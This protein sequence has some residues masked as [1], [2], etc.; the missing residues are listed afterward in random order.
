MKTY[1][2][3][4]QKKFNFTIRRIE[5][6][7]A[8]EK[9]VE[10]TD[11][12]CRGLLFRIEKTG[13]KTWRWRGTDRVS[14]KRV[15]L[16]L[17]TYPEMSLEDARNA[18]EENNLNL[19]EGVKPKT[20]LQK[21]QE[22]ETL[23]QLFER[24]LEEYAKPRK[25]S[26][27][28]DERQ[29]NRY[30]RAD[31]GDVPAEDITTRDLELW[32]G[33]LLK[34]K[35]ERGNG[36]L[37]TSTINRVHIVLSAVFSKSAKHIPNPA[38]GLEKYPTKHRNTF[39]KREMIP[40][41]LKALESEETPL[42]L[43]DLV[44]L[45]LATGARR[46]NLQTMTWREISLVDKTWT[47]P[48]DKMKNKEELVIPLSS[49]ALE[50]LERRDEKKTGLYVFPSRPGSKTPYLTEPKRAWKNLTERANLSG[51]RFHDLRRTAGSIM[52]AAGVP[53]LT[54]VRT[55]GQKSPEMIAVYQQ[56]QDNAQRDALNKASDLLNHWSEEKE[57]VVSI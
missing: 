51:L 10:Y 32:R 45:A 28:D 54:I 46:G 5:R 19:I 38:A 34:Q 20:E 31:F 15:V 33:R 8:Q 11:A 25:R 22:K 37:S 47:I 3:I 36:T 27:K 52:A 13:R 40:G 43:K 30:L 35:K 26:W 57:K 17:G 7:K 56:L 14:G 2:D 21:Q 41:F 50:V 29:Y 18:G 53:A 48:G 12:G 55:L 23:N 6:L 42:Y 1:R 9:A 24:H 49:S 39:I 44:K 16:T 4:M